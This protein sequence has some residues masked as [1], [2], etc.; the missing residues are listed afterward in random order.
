MASCKDI[1]TAHMRTND[2]LS[3]APFSPQKSPKLDMGGH[4]VFG[5]V[6][7]YLKIIRI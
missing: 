3:V 1:V 2:G 5:T 4:G 7:D 6:D